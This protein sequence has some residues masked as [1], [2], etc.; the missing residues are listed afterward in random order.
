MEILTQDAQHGNGFGVHVN[1]NQGRRT[2]II[3]C[4]LHTFRWKRAKQ[5]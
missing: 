4:F 5:G 1:I 2:P 3:S